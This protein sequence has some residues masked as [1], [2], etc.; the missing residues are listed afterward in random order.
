MPLNTLENML[1]TLVKASRI[2]VYELPLPCEERLFWIYYPEITPDSM[3]G[4][5]NSCKTF[6]KKRMQERQNRLSLHTGITSEMS[7]LLFPMICKTD[8]SDTHFLKSYFI[9][10]FLGCTPLH[11]SLPEKTSSA[12]FFSA[13]HVA[14]TENS[15]LDSLRNRHS[16]AH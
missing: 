7:L 15:G 13:A 4:R 14:S 6:L 9:T 5:Q 12:H 2:P 16:F 11:K 3:R 10:S 1:G 8:S